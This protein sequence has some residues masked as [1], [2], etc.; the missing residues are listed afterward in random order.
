M[1]PIFCVFLRKNGNTKAKN[2]RGK[3]MTEEAKILENIRQNVEMGIDSINTVSNKNTE[4]A[5][6]PQRL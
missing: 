1:R 2:E 6:I 5:L 3:K 4:N